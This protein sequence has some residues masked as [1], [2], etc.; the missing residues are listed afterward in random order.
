MDVPKYIV[1]S[2]SL[3]FHRFDHDYICIHKEKTTTKEKNR[4]NM[5]RTN[6]YFPLE[7]LSAPDR[8]IVEAWMAIN[9]WLSKW[10]RM[11]PAAAAFL[12][13]TWINTIATYILRNGRPLFYYQNL[14]D[15]NRMIIGPLFPHWVGG[16]C[17]VVAS[18]PSFHRH[19]HHC[20]PHCLR[21][22]HRNEV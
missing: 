1:Y 17:H 6:I 16:Y 9:V 5:H 3:A 13:S 10:R 8:T 18:Q 2:V 11:S 21:Y 22:Y 7:K 20:N 19:P 4:G 12:N 15:G 14:E